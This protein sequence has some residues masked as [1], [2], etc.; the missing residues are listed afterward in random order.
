M[1]HP[2]VALEALDDGRTLARAPAKMNLSLRVGPIGPDGY[3]RLDSVV[4][5]ITLYDELTFAVR[6]DDVLS[7]TCDDPAVAVGEENL[8][9]RAARALQP[10]SRGAGADIVL[11]KRIPTGAGL[12]GGSADAA[13]AL[14]AL[15][16]LW[17]CRHDACALSAVAAQLGSDVPL[18]LGSPAARIRGRGERVDA[19]ALHPF[20]AVLLTPPVHCSTA[21]VYR[22]YDAMGAHPLEPFD[23]APLGDSPPARWSD[24]LVNDLSAPACRACRQVERWWSKFSSAACEPVHMTGSGSALFVLADDVE[25]AGRIHRRLGAEL[26]GY[27]RVVSL[28]PW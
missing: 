9:L 15:N 26:I 13:A 14:H 22:A 28:N 7:L 18:F 20:A 4:A 6:G 2:A 19:V 11:R 1:S 23:P 8:V 5:K 16:Q 12:G 3:H 21:A 25:H 10:A 27:A 24:L 17:H